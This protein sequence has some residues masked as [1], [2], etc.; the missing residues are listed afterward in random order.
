MD[1][2]KSNQFPSDWKLYKLNKLGNPFNGL[3]G[4]TKE[5]FG[6]GKP[7]IPY[8]N[9]FRNAIIDNESFDYVRVNGEKNQNKV[10]YGDLFF[11]TSSETPKEVGMSSAY[12]GNNEELYLNSFCF[13]FRLHDFKLA[14]PEYLSYYFRSSLGRRFMSRLAQGATR[15]NLSKNL[16]LKEQIL[17]PSIVEQ[18]Q[19]SQIF[20]CWDEAINLNQSLLSESLKN[21]KGLEQHLLSGKVRFGEF[22]KSKTSVKTPV[23][24]LPE[25][26][27]L[28]HISDIVQRARKPFKPELEKLYREIGIRSHCKG[29]FHKEEVNGASLGN[30]SVFWIQPDC[31]V[32][33]IVFAWEHAIAKTTEAEVGMIASHRFPMYKPKKGVL[34]LDYLLYYFKTA[35][36]KH[37]LGLASPGGAGRNKTLGQSEFAKL[38]IPVPSIEEQKKIVAVLSEADK[39]IELLQQQIDTLKKQKKGLM[40]KLLTGE[41]R[42]KPGN[43]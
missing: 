28:K 19:I 37:L 21:R 35:R 18:Q 16:F 6:G 31:F 2:L 10:S 20:I 34:D 1:K 26:W 36:G 3:T 27:E 5:D 41:I 17:L 43:E 7:Y 8:L 4:K 39:E 13:G 32:V 15:Y 33:N 12:L 38:K 11:T 14:T 30:K 29:I 22:V 40:Q 25:D 42:V 24:I 9:I 23:G